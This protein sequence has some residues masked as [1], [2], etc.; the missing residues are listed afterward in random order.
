MYEQLI[1]DQ[2]YLKKAVGFF[3][4]LQTE[5]AKNESN[6]KGLSVGKKQD[7]A[8]TGAPHA[9]RTGSGDR[10]VL[11]LRSPVRPASVP[12]M[13]PA[14]LLPTQRTRGCLPAELSAGLK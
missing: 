1:L 3:F 11:M 12:R 6:T 13:L 10:H 7:P 2:L 14:G 9:W 5:E 4:N 8:E